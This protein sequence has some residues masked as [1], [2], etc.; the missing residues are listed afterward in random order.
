[1]TMDSRVTN[2][3][4]TTKAR[5]MDVAKRDIMNAVHSFQDLTPDTETFEFP[6]R[7]RKLTFR[8]KGTIPVAYKVSI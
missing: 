4:Q 7:S 6:D 1:M 2:A 8:L 5:Y 3:L